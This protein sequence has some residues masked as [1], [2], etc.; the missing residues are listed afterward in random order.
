M[1]DA[2]RAD[3][4]PVLLRALRDAD[5]LPVLLAVQAAT[6]PHA[7]RMEHEYA[8]RDLLDS[9]WAA[10]PLALL[11]DAEKAG[12]TT[13][14][15][16]ADSGGA[17]LALSST[18]LD[19]PDFLSLAAAITLALSHAHHSRLVHRDL[20]AAHILF[21]PATASVRLTGFGLATALDGPDDPQADLYRL[22]QLLYHLLAGAP[23]PAADGDAEALAPHRGRPG[24]D[25]ICS[26]IVARLL[27][28]D[29]AQRYQSAAGLYADLQHCRS[30]LEAQGRVEPF[31]LGCHDG[32]LRV[33]I[34][35]VL[36]GRAP[37]L[38]LLE[39]ALAR[40]AA[41]CAPQLVLVSGSAGTGKSA[42]VA[43]LRHSEAALGATVIAGKFDQRQRD[44][45][46]ATLAQ[47]FQALV[48][49]RLR[50]GEAALAPWR[51]ALLAAL[52]PNARLMLDLIPE[53]A[54]VI[55]AHPGP[56]PLAPPEAQSRF[57]G[58]FRRFL[59]A[60]RRP[61][62]ALLLCLDDV[63]WI[64]PAS[65]K[66]L[67]HLLT[68]PGMDHVLAICAWRTREEGGAHPMALAR[69]AMLANGATMGIAVQA[70]VHDIVLEA[71]DR[72]QAC[73]LM[74]AALD[75][76]IAEAAPLAALVYPK[77]AG[78]PF[79]TLQFLTRLGENRL[80]R[81]DD[82][83]ARWEWDAQ[84]I[85][86]RAFSD[87]VID[88]MVA[89]LGQLPGC[90]L[91]LVKLLACLGPD[92]GL[93]TIAL[94]SG[95]SLLETDETLWPAARLGLI[96]REPG[97]YRFAHDRVQEG[98]YSMIEPST[99]P[100]RHL[101]IGRLL[102]ANVVPEALDQYVFDIVHH[103]NRARTAMSAQRELRE[104]AQLNA[105]AGIK[106]RN[107]IAYDSARNYF[108][109]AAG[110]T[111][112]R[113]W[114]DDVDGTYAMYA[115]LAECEY[116][117]GHLERAGRLFDLLVEQA[118]SRSDLARVALLRVAV[119]QLRGRF[120]QA[121]AV[122]FDALAL[123]GVTF[124]SVRA[125][126][127]WALRDERA[128]IAL[129]MD[130]RSIDSLGALPVSTDPE[131]AIVAELLSDVG[132]PVFSARPELYFLLAAKALNYTLTH[133]RTESSCMIYSRYAILLVSLGAIEDAFAFSALAIEQ[134]QFN[135]PPSKRSGRLRFVH[136]AYIHSWRD[137][138]A[139][140]VEPLREA[141]ASCERAGDLPHAGYA[142]HVATWNAFEA[143]LPLAEV[144]RMA[145][146]YQGFARRHA[147][148]ALLRLLR[149]YEQLAETF[150]GAGDAAGSIAD[151]GQGSFGAARA[152][153]LLMQ[154]VAAFSFGR[155]EEALA[156]SEAAAANLH[157]FLAS[158]NETTHHFYHALAM[159]ALYRSA[160]PARR[161]R[162]LEAV[163]DKH[164]LLAGWAASCPV[165]FANRYLLVG[166]ELARIDGN[167]VAAM[168]G[169]EAAIAS[170]MQGG[171]VQ[172]AALA[173]ELAAA[174]RDELG[175]TA[176]A[177]AYAR[178]ALMAWSGWG[179]QAKVRDVLRRYPALSAWHKQ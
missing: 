67:S 31:V 14:L 55:G 64:D 91:D 63:Q 121:V 156:A 3:P 169:Y 143:G 33:R 2:L 126:I 86:A 152:R 113:A 155:Y 107:A 172:N 39:A 85:Q 149:G 49:E 118:R 54:L 92:A 157:F 19:L 123:F 178:R 32:A 104:L 162:L 62:T 128:A 134:V 164:A 74:A 145:A 147:N 140:S 82:A 79:F 174:C 144:R 98:A 139:T 133:G 90:T 17:P 68:H 1:I 137:P 127:D 45:P 142:A 28:P 4:Q 151:F 10:T 132:S 48:R 20:E 40:A 103:L 153:Y 93:D 84:A 29:P 7:G 125:E 51:A 6:H 117:C 15:V 158:L 76:D 124:P 8:L 12:A 69:D 96:V 95:M 105:L 130:G 166:A 5:R 176:G 9:A 30:M 141:F 56:P 34:P 120:D 99:L 58:V 150:I 66:L 138:I 175:D 106:A 161:R 25:R 78:N 75:C 53:L 146:H 131:V 46:Y 119:Y 61:G 148:H 83:A 50:E 129:R 88:L 168:E 44:I 111:P 59:Q 43:A 41:G 114:K 97:N 173:C 36:V 167:P 80:L 16:L 87:N 122:A 163:C 60:C 13:T 37:Q 81:F 23:A 11:H 102:R 109:L 170:A 108:S 89:R 22:G 18:P 94:V 115:A 71:L 70:D 136:A 110:L 154:Q 21:D 171:F 165:N 42:L 26:S 57:D 72:A 47:A 177:L 38:A 100:E 159:T 112:S 27:A 24:V 116:L 65:L 179:A 52:G 160:A 73:E 35:A 101:H 135:A 77:T